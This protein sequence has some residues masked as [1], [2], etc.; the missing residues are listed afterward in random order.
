VELGPVDSGT[1]QAVRAGDELVVALPENPTTGYRWYPDVDTDALAQEEDHNEGPVER[2]GAPG[3]RYL[4]FRA[5]RPGPTRLRLIKK[6]PWE[7]DPVE[8]FAVDLDI[9]V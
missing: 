9:F 7:A 4:A 8:E 5:L 2:R 1:R 6:R 3:T